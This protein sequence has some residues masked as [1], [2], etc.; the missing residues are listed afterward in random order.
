M[1][2]ERKIL[3]SSSTWLY[4][5][6]SVFIV[7]IVSLVGILTISIN[8]RK[9]KSAVFFMVSLAVG[10]LFGDAF[11]HL[12]PETFEKFGASL[13]SSLYVLSGLLAFFVLE[14][15][16]HWRHEH[17]VGSDSGIQPVGY[18][19]LAADGLH[20]FIDGLLI[21]ASYL[22][23]TEVGIATTL[24]VILHEVPQEIGD[25]GVLIHAGFSKIKALLLN[26]LSATM[27]IAGAVVALSFGARA[28]NFAS[29]MLPF[30]AGGFI[31]IAGCD[32][33]PELH[34]ETSPAKSALQLLAIAIGV[35]FMLLILWIE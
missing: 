24:A 10:A 8:E 11:L 35:G 18:M 14:K 16:L 34:K 12:L 33:V 5:L 1:G 28:E 32:L 21:G 31:Y 26:F 6:G 7:S 23:S 25:F 22:I 3:A 17:T 2:A 19:N 4:T 15:F 27:A 13:Q 9:L 29:L 30:A 20:N